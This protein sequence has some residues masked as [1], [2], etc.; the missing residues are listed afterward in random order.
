MK[1]HPGRVYPGRRMPGHMGN[2]Q[3]TTQNLKVVQVRK[4]DQLLLIKGA[5]PGANGG[6]ILVKQAIKKAHGK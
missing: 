5:I 6:F 2:V 1:E 4:E 3:R